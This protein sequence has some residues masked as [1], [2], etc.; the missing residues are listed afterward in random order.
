MS[1]TERLKFNFPRFVGFN[2]PF[3]RLALPNL[4]G[5]IP[6]FVLRRLNKVVP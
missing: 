2:I 1:T 3:F 4:L 5:L 6:S